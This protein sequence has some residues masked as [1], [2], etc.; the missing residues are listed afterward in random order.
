[1]LNTKLLELA[2]AT[3]LPIVATN[4]CHYLEAADVEAHDI[5]LCIQ[6]QAKVDDEKRMRF[7]A[8]DLYYKSAEERKP[9]FPMCPRRWKI[10]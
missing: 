1:M 3:K 4:D 6:T 2:E 9:P 10:R 8:K 5:L 7:E